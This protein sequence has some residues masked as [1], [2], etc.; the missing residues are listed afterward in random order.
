MFFPDVFYPKVVDDCL[1][2]DQGARERGK[3]D[4]KFKMHLLF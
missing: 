2:V 3:A 1:D 4:K